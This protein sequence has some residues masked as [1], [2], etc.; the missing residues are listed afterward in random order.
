MN[1]INQLR[2]ALF[3]TLQ[4]VK[5]GDMDISRAKAISEVAQTIINTA[6]VEIDYMQA[7][8][9]DVVSGF[10]GNPQQRSQPVLTQIPSRQGVAD[11][12]T[13][14]NVRRNECK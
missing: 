6:K 11:Q 14:A 7:S 9:A 1:D 10:I 5:S 13:A 2:S 8:G 3:E 4:S 12:L